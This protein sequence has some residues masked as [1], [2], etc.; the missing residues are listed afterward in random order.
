MKPLTT[1][2]K[3]LATTLFLFIAGVALFRLIE[4]PAFGFDEGWATQVGMNIALHGSD[5]LQFAPGQVTHVSVLTSVGYTLIY[6]LAFWLKLFGAGVFQARLMMTAYM[7]AMA[8][9]GFI[10]AR[11]LLGNRFAVASLALLATLPPFFVFGKQVAGE[12]PVMT[13]MLLHLLFLNLGLSGNTSRRGFWLVLAGLAAGLCIVT[14]T[15]ALV[16]APVLIVCAAIALRRKIVNLT[17]ICMVLAAALPPV[18]VWIAVNFQQGDT[19]ASVLD[20]YSNPAAVTDAAGNLH[21][22]LV[23]L[24]TTPGPL[25]ALGLVAVW[26]AGIVIRFVRRIRLPIE[27]WIAVAYTIAILCA[28]MRLYGDVRYL[29]P[30]EVLAILFAPYSAYIALDS[31][32]NMSDAARGRIFMAGIAV[33]ALAGAYQI[34]F[35]SYLADSYAST[36]TDELASYMGSLPASTTVFFYNA[37]NAVPFFKGRNYYQRIVMFE[38]WRLGSDFGTVVGS[39]IPEVLLINSPSKDD[40]RVSLNGYTFKASFDKIMV[41]TRSAAQPPR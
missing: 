11:R 41:Y 17:D 16:F 33:I 34:G 37:T 30:V 20:Y 31:F 1:N 19:L 3:I 25:F 10:L 21:R 13:F 5:G 39:R 2:Q 8:A 7:L 27:E 23:L 24:F 32:R 22:N 40:R 6:A 38:K 4:S 15:S 26:F 29:F 9:V 28:F 18:A 12:V 14:K 36:S 35:H